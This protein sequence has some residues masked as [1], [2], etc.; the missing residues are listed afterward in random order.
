VPIGRL[1]PGQSTPVRI[2]APPQIEPYRGVPLSGALFG[3][4]GSAPPGAPPGYPGGYQPPADPEQL[5]RGQFLDLM[6]MSSGP[7]YGPF[8][9]SFPLTFTAF[10]RAP[11][12]RGAPLPEGHPSYQLT[13]LRQT[14]QLTL[15]PGQF[16]MPAGLIPASMLDTT[17]GFSGG[18]SGPNGPFFFDL[19]GGSLTFSFKPPLPDEAMVDALVLTTEQMGVG[20]LPPGVTAPPGKGPPGP[21]EPAAAGVFS[22]Y[23]WGRSTWTPL[24]AGARHTIPAEAFVG[25]GGEVR[26]RAAAAGSSSGRVIQ[27]TLAMEGTAGVSQ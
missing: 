5:R 15:T 23:D 8:A 6:L 12:V 16:L 26:V 7:G 14:L 2:S 21:V 4:I 9:R 11:T 22:L 1:A 25:P 24:P 17:F 20:P 27:P 3:T 10:T 18:S 13:L 19:Q